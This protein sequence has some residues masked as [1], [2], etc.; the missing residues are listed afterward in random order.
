M[1][2]GEVPSLGA[3]CGPNSC[4]H[5]AWAV[6]TPNSF[7]VDPTR[8]APLP[9][10]IDEVITQGVGFY[11]ARSTG[12]TIMQ[13]L[14]ARNEHFNEVSKSVSSRAKNQIFD[15]NALQVARSPDRSSYNENYV[16]FDNKH[17]DR[18]ARVNYRRMM[19]LTALMLER[20]S[21]HLR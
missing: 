17:P 7:S 11:K 18:N 10:I 16:D 13:F 1:N 9:Q 12:K 19:E 5:C 21:S 15:S 3:H 14:D 20:Q 6:I 2:Q 8:C 4:A